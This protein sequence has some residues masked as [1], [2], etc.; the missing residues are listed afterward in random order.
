MKVSELN[1]NSL[2]L[3]HVFLFQVWLLLCLLS[4]LLIP[5]LAD[6]NAISL[7]RFQTAQ[8]TELQ[9]SQ[10]DTDL[11]QL[12]N[13]CIEYA[14]DYISYMLFIIR[15]ECQKLEQTPHVMTRYTRTFDRPGPVV[16]TPFVSCKS[17]SLVL[18][19]L[20]IRNL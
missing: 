12:C 10:C 4:T 6:D 3:P 18:Y 8:S 20:S 9:R 15:S 7:K 2:Y 13:I 17:F 1:V 5:G 16:A 19:S 11:D 14:D